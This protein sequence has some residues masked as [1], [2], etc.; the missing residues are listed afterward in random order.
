MPFCEFNGEAVNTGGVAGGSITGGSGGPC[1]TN[2]GFC[3]IEELELGNLPWELTTSTPDFVTID[4]MTFT[5]HFTSG[6]SA[7][8]LPSEVSWA[9]TVTGTIDLETQCITFTNAEGLK[10]EASSGPVTLN[11]ELCIGEGPVLT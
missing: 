7:I 8:G 1:G 9:G 5:N 6:C 11:G 4:A 3:E 2:F 10:F